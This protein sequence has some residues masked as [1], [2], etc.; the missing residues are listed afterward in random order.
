MGEG[1][2][3]TLTGRKPPLANHPGGPHSA[4]LAPRLW[5]F[6]QLPASFEH[7][8]ERNLECRAKLRHSDSIDGLPS[9]AGQPTPPAERSAASASITNKAIEYLM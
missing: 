4:T 1:W 6:A 2:V 8:T 5:Y 9:I 7:G 3:A